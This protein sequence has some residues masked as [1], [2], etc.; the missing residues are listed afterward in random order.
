MSLFIIVL[1]K[2]INCQY[3]GPSYTGAFTALQ[4]DLL[5]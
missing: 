5:L 4:L 3:S 2:N 1:L